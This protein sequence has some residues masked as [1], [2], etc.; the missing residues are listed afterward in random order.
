MGFT[1]S[2]FTFFDPNQDLTTFC[3]SNKNIFS[4][5]GQNSKTTPTSM[6]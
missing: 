6:I 4:S 5:C 3:D 2:V 1:N